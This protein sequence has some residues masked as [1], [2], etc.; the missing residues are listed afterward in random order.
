MKLRHNPMTTHQS[1]NKS[2]QILILVLILSI[3]VLTTGLLT[4][5]LTSEE[6]RIAKLEADSKK[7]FAAAEAGLEASLQSSQPITDLGALLG[8]S[9]SGITGSTT[10]QTVQTANFTTPLLQ[11][12]EQ[13][14]FYLSQ[15]TPPSPTDLELTQDFG[16]VSSSKLKIMLQQ[17]KSASYC[18]DNGGIHKLA[19]ELTFINADSGD[20]DFGIRKRMV[21][22]ACDI[23]ATNIDKTGF[24][25]TIDMSAFPSHI[26]LLRV[27]APNNS[28]DGAIFSI[29]NESEQEW[30][31][32]GKTVVSTATTT[33]SVSQKIQLFQSYPQFAADFWVTSF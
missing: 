13:Y 6:T 3:I 15:Y 10:I 26:L 22:D 17:P 20:P 11:K 16:S 23:L 28:F 33:T 5:R 32:Q 2:G 29:V 4:T 31:P 24:D 21:I 18:T 27:I 25:T 12:D 30:Y 9:S 19:L 14:T 1:N 7:A 8:G